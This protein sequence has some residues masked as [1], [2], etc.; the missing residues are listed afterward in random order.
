M[1][2]LI[3]CCCFQEV[4]FSLEVMI[5]LD[6]YVSQGRYGYLQGY[7]VEFR[8]QG[9]S[10]VDTGVDILV[11]ICVIFILYQILCEVFCIFVMFLLIR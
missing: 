6:D 1:Q 7:S 4:G 3:N 2:G 10:Q 8:I 11:D 9:F 5:W